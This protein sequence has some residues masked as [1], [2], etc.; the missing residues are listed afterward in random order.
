[1]FNYGLKNLREVCAPEE[2]QEI[3][4][5]KIWTTFCEILLRV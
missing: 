3:D 4:A 5:D 1:M 2:Y